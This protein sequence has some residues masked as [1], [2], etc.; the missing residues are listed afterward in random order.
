M[1]CPKSL[2]QMAQEN[3]LRRATGL[4][5]VQDLWQQNQ[6]SGSLPMLQQGWEARTFSSNATEQR[7]GYQAAASDLDCVRGKRGHPHTCPW[8]RTLQDFPF[9]R[10][11][12]YSDE[13]GHGHSNFQKCPNSFY[14]LK[15]TPTNLSIGLDAKYLWKSVLWDLTILENTFLKTKRDHDAQVPWPP[16]E[17]RTE[18]GTDQFPVILVPCESIGLFFS[19][20][21]WWYDQ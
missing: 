21:G 20:V 14:G 3:Q 19:L 7:L 18:N 10:F 6:G 16:A 13:V 9:W 11:S 8:Q 2:T 4:W 17:L 5:Q 15:S 1:N 12:V